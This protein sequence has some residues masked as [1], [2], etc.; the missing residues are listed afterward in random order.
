VKPSA[1]R[2][3]AAETYKRQIFGKILLLISLQQVVR[4][5]TRKYRKIL[6]AFGYFGKLT[7]SILL[8]NSFYLCPRF[9]MMFERGQG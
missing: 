1:E 3:P 2:R 8:S 5:K 9:F 7:L 6:S 4:V